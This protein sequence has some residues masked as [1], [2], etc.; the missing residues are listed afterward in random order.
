MARR[1][2]TIRA[3]DPRSGRRWVAGRMGFTLSRALLMGDNVYEAMVS[4]GFT[5]GARIMELNRP[6]VPDIVW[7]ACVA[8]GIFAVWLSG[9]FK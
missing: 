7:T 9:G 2:R 5:G 1:S 6:G 8:C 4:R 3:A